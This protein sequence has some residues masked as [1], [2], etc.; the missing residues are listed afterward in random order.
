MKMAEVE[1]STLYTRLEALE[2]KLS[3]QEDTIE[4]LNDVVTSQTI[5]IQKLWDANRLLKAS[6]SELRAG[7]PGSNEAEPPPPHY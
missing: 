1:I 5:E 3:F 4:Q 7:Q 2:M 6:L